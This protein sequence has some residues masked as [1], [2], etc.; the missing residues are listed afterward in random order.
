MKMSPIR[1]PILAPVIDMIVDGL[2][3]NCLPND[4]NTHYNILELAV[5]HQQGASFTMFLA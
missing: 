2:F 5:S 3:L 1:I 4:T